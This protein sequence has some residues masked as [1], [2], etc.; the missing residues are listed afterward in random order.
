[1]ARFV[2]RAL[3]VCAALAVQVAYASEPTSAAARFL[4]QLSLKGNHLAWQNL[5]PGQN[6]IQVEK[7]LGSKLAL[8]PTATPGEGAYTNEASIVRDGVSVRLGF[9][10]QGRD[11]VLT[12]IRANVPALSKTQAAS[13]R[14]EAKVQ[15][16]GLRD[17][18]PDF[19]LASKG[20]EE[21]DIS[22]TDVRLQV[23]SDG[24]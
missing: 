23:G 15:L 7:Q 5:R 11:S 21:L 14:K 8:K 24:E 2:F 3:I 16:K 12:E 10:R 22:E 20:G 6:Q 13:L 18:G 17:S 19:P 4:T 9:Y 1:M